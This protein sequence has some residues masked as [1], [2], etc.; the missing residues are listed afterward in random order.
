VG[1]ISV[2]TPKLHSFDEENNTQIYEDLPSSL[3][4]KTYC[5]SHSL[6]KPECH[7]LGLAVGQWAKQFHSW[8][9]EDGQAALLDSMKGNEDM[10]A[11]KFMINYERLV[12]S[13]ETFPDL[14][15]ESRTVFEDVREGM[16][17]SVEEEGQVQLIH[18]DFW[19]GK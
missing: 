3:D 15:N 13:I 2:Q 4:L 7:R 10:K 11:L 12:G 18:G 9:Q 1:G 14:L 5:L 17:K 16:R 6:S 19:S 8:A